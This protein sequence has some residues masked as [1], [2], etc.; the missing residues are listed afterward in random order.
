MK[1]FERRRV[2][3]T[4]AI[5]LAAAGG[6]GT[7]MTRGSKHEV[8]GAPQVA[9]RV[10]A[11]PYRRFGRTGLEVSELAF[12]AWAIGGESYGAV[13]RA[14]SLAALARAEELGCNVVDTAGVYG[15]SEAVLGEFLAGRRDRWVVA[16]KFSGQAAGMTATIEDQ[17]RRLGTDYIDFYM[18]HWLP[19]GADAALLDELAALKRAGKA[20]FVGISVYGPDDVD[21]VIDS[22]DLDGLMLPLSLLDPDPFRARR[23][24]LAASGKA[25]M[26]RSALKEGFLTGKYSPGARF[27][28]PKD[29]RSRMSAAQVAARIGQVERMR[30]LEA[31]AGSLVRAAIAYPLSFPE[32]ATTVLGVKTAAH[33]DVNFG[34][35][36]GARLSATALD[37][38]AQLQESMGLR[39]PTGWRRLLRRITG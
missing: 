24:R 4:G 19:T 8:V 1:T 31:E 2:L 29:Q 3:L 17:L 18:V 33:A 26:A 23:A 34:E 25:V 20:R 15:D 6:V 38:V 28:D 12:G 37:Q 9:R 7:F 16:T 22:P 5:A 10:G 35:C 13:E 36:A 11:M 21:F 14:Q 32:V 39:A 27:T 30:F